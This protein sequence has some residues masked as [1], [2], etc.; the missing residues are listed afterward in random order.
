M[1]WVRGHRFEPMV[2]RYLF[3]ALH[4]LG[5]AWESGRVSVAA[6]HAAS[7]A[8]AR[9]LGCCLRRRRLDPANV[10][11][12]VLVGLPTGALE[13]ELGAMAPCH[14]GATS[15]AMAV[16]VRRRRRPRSRLGSRG[17]GDDGEGRRDRCPDRD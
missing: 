12:P 11:R 14:R 6:E 2:D 1:R 9:W 15:R 16:V 5:E 4:A 13:H 8:A 7:A 3:P 17:E 10:E